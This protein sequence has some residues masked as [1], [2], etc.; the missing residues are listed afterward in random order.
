MNVIGS[1][2]E[3]EIGST[4]INAQYSVPMQTCF[5]NMGHLQPPT[6]IRIENINVE[7][8]YKVIPNQKISKAIRMRF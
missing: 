1:M 7:A 2:A 5:I 8:F 4:Y 3:S 6:K